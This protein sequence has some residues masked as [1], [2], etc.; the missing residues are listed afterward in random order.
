MDCTPYLGEEPTISS[1]FGKGTRPR[2]DRQ[3]QNKRSTKKDPDKAV[4]TEESKARLDRND[5][6]GS[7]EN[8]RSESQDLNGSGT[9][10]AS[11][12]SEG[13]SEEASSTSTE[14]GGAAGNGGNTASLHRLFLPQILQLSSTNAL[15]SRTDSKVLELHG[16]EAVTEAPLATTTTSDWPTENVIAKFVEIFNKLESNFEVFIWL[17]HREVICMLTELKRKHWSGPDFESCDF[18]RLLHRYPQD[19][20]CVCLLR[21]WDVLRAESQILKKMLRLQA[22]SLVDPRIFPVG[23]KESEDP[24]LL[25]LMNSKETVLLDL[26]KTGAFGRGGYYSGDG[27]SHLTEENRP[28]EAEPH[29]KKRFASIATQKRTR[30]VEQRRSEKETRRE[31]SRALHEQDTR[32]KSTKDQSSAFRPRKTPERFSPSDYAKTRDECLKSLN[33][34]TSEEMSGIEDLVTERNIDALHSDN[35]R[36]KQR[37]KDQTVIWDMI[38]EEVEGCRETPI[39]D[40]ESD[41]ETELDQQQLL[42]DQKALTWKAIEDLA[43]FKRAESTDREKQRQDAIKAHNIMLS[44]DRAYAMTQS[45]RHGSITAEER[46]KALNAIM[47]AKKAM[48]QLKYDQQAAIHKSSSEIFEAKKAVHKLQDQAKELRLQSRIIK[49]MLKD[50]GVAKQQA[51]RALT[52]IKGKD[53]TT[54]KAQKELLLTAF[55]GPTI[56][57]SKDRLQK[58]LSAL[59]GDKFNCKDLKELRCLINVLQRRDETLKRKQVLI[60]DALKEVKHRQEIVRQMLKRQTDKD[61]VYRLTDTVLRDSLDK[62]TKFIED[63]NKMAELAPLPPSSTTAATTA[64]V[65]GEYSDEDCSGTMEDEGGERKIPSAASWSQPNSQRA[66]GQR[67]L[68]RQKRASL[69]EDLEKEDQFDSIEEISVSVNADDLD[70]DGAVN[71]INNNFLNSTSTKEQVL[72][73]KRTEHSRN[74]GDSLEDV[75][76]E[77]PRKPKRRAKDLLKKAIDL[78]NRELK[79]RVGEK[80]SMEEQYD[81]LYDIWRSAEEK[82]RD[83]LGARKEIN[84]RLFKAI[85]KKGVLLGSIFPT[86]SR[87]K[88]VERQLSDMPVQEEASASTDGSV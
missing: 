62:I 65:T 32:L 34:D 17:L 53:L 23:P 9:S 60:K 12:S 4:E 77:R 44:A 26:M 51:K 46:I 45:F 37:I 31:L 84:S 80:D 52:E 2:G 41:V 21:K 73:V 88:Q 61:N 43:A 1:T 55:T 83:D 82:A 30:V 67:I 42:G 47:N 68:E 87:P 25:R 14:E 75:T 3:A 38:E 57:E 74:P 8:S 54:T 71:E 10:E 85:S 27:E 28:L 66:S 20:L 16:R 63:L 81:K 69:D 22:N 11:K 78:P 58:Y 56:A 5:K 86:A 35:E 15:K 49:L 6:F 64:V 70:R 36:S 33:R 29:S 19:D 13:E 50:N 72:R 48:V 59:Q 76:E 7:A 79:Q 40:E 24:D 18:V 39:C